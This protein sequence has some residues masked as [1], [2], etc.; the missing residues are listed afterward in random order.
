MLADLQFLQDLQ[1]KDATPIFRQIFSTAFDGKMVYGFFR[2]RIKAVNM[3]DCD[4]PYMAACVIHSLSRSTIFLT[5]NYA[6]FDMPQ[7][8]RVSILV[9]ESRHTEEDGGFWMH[10]KC[11][12]PYRDWTGKPVVSLIT[13][14]PL[15]GQP[16]CDHTSYGAYGLQA[17]LLKNTE[18]YCENCN[19]KVKLDARIFGVDMVR[20]ISNPAASVEIR[21]D[22]K[23]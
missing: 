3:D 2:D 19:E 22:L 5:D 13:H 10:D 14:A 1:G 12:T 11:P 6:K 16:A 8:Y 23:I 21:R 17:E 9:H 18:M 15:D 7:L 20:R 4:S